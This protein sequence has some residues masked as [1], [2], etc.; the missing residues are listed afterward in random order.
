MYVAV[1]HIIT[2]KMILPHFNVIS[3]SNIMLVLNVMTKCVAIV[4]FP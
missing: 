4:L 2:M 3:V 1:V